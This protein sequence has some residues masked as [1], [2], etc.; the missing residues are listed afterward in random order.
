MADVSSGLI[1]LK[2]T[3]FQLPLKKII[4]ITRCGHTRPA[5]PFS[6]GRLLRAG[7]VP[8]RQACALSH[9]PA[10]QLG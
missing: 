6:E 2:K 8:L 4:K 3:Y 10:H 7:A 1:F 5:F 9:P